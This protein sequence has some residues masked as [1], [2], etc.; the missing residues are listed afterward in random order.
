MRSQSTPQLPPLHW[1]PHSMVW[2]ATV[3]AASLSQSSARQPKAWTMGASV[4]PVSVT[5]PVMTM[6]APWRSACTTGA[7]PR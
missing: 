2:P 6:S 1:A 7:A 3:P 4:S 5:R